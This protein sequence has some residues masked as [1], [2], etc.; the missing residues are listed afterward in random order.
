[1]GVDD[2]WREQEEE[3][4]ANIQRRRLEN[5]MVGEV[6]KL[7]LQFLSYFLSWPFKV[8]GLSSVVSD[9]NFLK[10]IYTLLRLCK[11][12]GKVKTSLM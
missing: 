2:N 8:A 6:Y 9:I 4:G 3:T 5:N 10:V 7:V 11:R 1:M 12:F